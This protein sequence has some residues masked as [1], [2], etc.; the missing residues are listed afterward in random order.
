MKRLPLAVAYATLC[1]SL[2]ACSSSDSPTPD[3]PTTPPDTP[4]TTPVVAHITPIEELN[5]GDDAV[6]SHADETDRAQLTMN[7]RTYTDITSSS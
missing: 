1:V 5:Q 4:P 2:A 6:N 7:Y 3:T